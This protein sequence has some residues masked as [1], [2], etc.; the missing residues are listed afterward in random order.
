MATTDTSLDYVMPPTTSLDSNTNSSENVPDSTSSSTSY[1]H[2]NANGSGASK[3][4]TPE[5]SSSALAIIDERLATDV[6]SVY[7]KKR[8]EVVKW[9]GWGYRDAEFIIKDDVIWFKGEKYPLNGQPLPLF[10]EWVLN[11]FNC[12]LHK[13]ATRPAAP[14]EY[15]KP[16]VNQEFLTALESSGISYSLDGLDR[17]MRCHGQTLH[18]IYYLIQN[19]FERIPDIV[20]WPTCHDDVVTLVNMAH[21]CNAVIIPYGGGTSV[22]GAITCPQ[23]EKRMICILDTSQMNRML[24]LN[25][26]NLTVCFEAGIVGQDLE[27]TLQSHGVT[28]GHEPDSYEFS[29]L[30]G[31]VATR[32]SGMKKNVYGNIEDLVVQVKMVTPSGVLERNCTAP[33][34]S[35]GP[36]FNHVILGSEGTL[37][38][39]TEVVLKLRPLPKVKRYNSLVFP[40]FECGV[41]F[42]R[43]VAK[44]RCQPSS[45]R[46]MDNEQFIMGQSLKPPKDWRSNIKDYLKKKY[47]TMIKGID[48]DQICAATLLFEG[49]LEEV[50]RREEQM[51]SIAKKFKGFAGGGENGER[52][53]VLTFVIAYIR[54]L[55]LQH[56]IVA[57]SFETSVPWDRCARLCENVKKR[58]V[59]E[60]HARSVMHFSISCRVTQTYDAG[61]CVYFYYAF[62][63]KGFENPVEL[64]EQ[65]ED[66]AREEMIMEGGSISHHH[67]V[68]KLR[69][70]W[71]E[72]TVT[73]TGAELF[74]ATKNRL[75]PKNIFAAGNLLPADSEQ[76]TA[77]PNS[78]ELTNLTNIR[79]ASKL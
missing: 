1:S 39:V 9:Y 46:L 47:V 10:T 19:I 54:D 34:I 43:E 16:T 24:W 71:F 44:Q 45:V 75:D 37:G 22:S 12:L 21:R 72:K 35:C 29:T 5:S 6:E 4:P 13:D 60:S 28:V 77:L 26:S 76:K 49:D 18:D 52:G 25:K 79:V 69:A 20:V 73:K 78:S 41:E 8:H 42:M 70:H 3:S 7:P 62:N 38:V 23:N 32:A 27:R 51:I 11:R 58:V 59:L 14:A 17:F 50:N 64:F 56:D 15:P 63:M 48:L 40:N 57:E 65:I 55:G 31:W 33:R 2:T 61:A 67:G 36:D 68:G 74:K 66:A 53:Y 30:G